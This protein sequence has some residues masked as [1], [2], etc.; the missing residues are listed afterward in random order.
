MLREDEDGN[1]EP[2]PI[3]TEVEWLDHINEEHIHPLGQ[4][5]GDGPSTEHI[6]SRL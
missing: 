2:T 4:V 1:I 6:G 3:A 5:H